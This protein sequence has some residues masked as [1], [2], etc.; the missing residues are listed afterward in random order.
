[1]ED[2]RR[3]CLR[4]WRSIVQGRVRSDHVVVPAPLLDDDAGLL[5]TA[6][7]ATTRRPPSAR[8]RANTVR[9]RVRL[10]SCVGAA[11]MNSSAREGLTATPDINGSTGSAV[12]GTSGGGLRPEAARSMEGLSSFVCVHASHRLGRRYSQLTPVSGS[13]RCR[14][15]ARQISTTSSLRWLARRASL[16]NLSMARK[17]N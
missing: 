12:C 15:A 17:A 13:P 1:M 11:A 9:S 8:T 16:T 6:K 10:K 7:I 5:Q 2:F 4:C 3:G 14:I